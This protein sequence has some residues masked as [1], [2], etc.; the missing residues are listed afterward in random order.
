MA[1]YNTTNI[2]ESNTMYDYFAAVNSLSSGLFASFMLFVFFLI[3]LMVFKGRYEM[4]QLMVGDSFICLFLAVLMCPL[5]LNL[6]GY[7]VVAICAIALF[8]SIVNLL[9]NK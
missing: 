6:V 8:V 1:I 9:F 3:I 5:W 4:S 2:T 7:T